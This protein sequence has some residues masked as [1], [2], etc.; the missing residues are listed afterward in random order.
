MRANENIALTATHTLFAREHNRIVG[1]LPNIAVAGGQVPDRPA[2]RHRGAAVHHLQGVAAGDGRGPAAV[3][4]LQ[5]Q[6]QRRRSPTSS[7]RSAT[8]RTARSTASS[9]SRR[10]VGR[11]TPGRP[12]VFEAQGIEVDRRRRR[13]RARGPAERRVLQP[14]PAPAIGE[15]P[16]LQALGAESQYN[17]DEQIDN[18][19][20]SVLFQIPTSPTTRTAWTRPT[21]PKC[22]N[23]VTDLGAIDIE[24]GRDH[25]IGTL[26]PAPPGVR[27]A[28][29]DVVHRDHRRV[30]RPVPGRRH[31]STTPNSL[32]VTSAVRHRRQRRS[33]SND[34]DAVEATGDPRRPPQHR[35]RPAAGRSTATST[36]STPSPA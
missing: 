32:D 16:L 3:H 27:P 17:N 20:R 35:G 25:G 9:S 12:R 19:L 31:A 21:L 13:G 6:R 5:V 15:G 34:E 36:T 29:E 11:Y 33:T 8:G 4:R 26:Q 23:G 22:F 30:D 10:R 18:E 14:R 24:R 2:G 1:L 7:P 28:G